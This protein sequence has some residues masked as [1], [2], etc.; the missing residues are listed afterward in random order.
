MSYFGEEL[1][2][3]LASKSLV[4]LQLADRTGISPSQ[5]SKWTR[6]E[7][8]SINE[9]Q[10][11][12]IQAALGDDP[13]DHA[14]LVLAHLLDEKFGLSHE[15]VE[16]SIQSTDLLKDTPRPKSK[17]ESALTFLAQE[18]LKNRELND[19]LIDLARLLRPDV[20]T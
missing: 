20:E 13:A 2:R 12:V 4:A 7:Q 17:G 16:L 18:R 14:R 11:S 6:G 8:T 5:I 19:L 1:T 15:L 3:Q 9:Q 10:I